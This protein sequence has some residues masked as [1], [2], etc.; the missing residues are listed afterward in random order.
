[1][2]NNDT[3]VAPDA[4][5][6]LVVEASSD[7][8][9][10][11]VGSLIVDLRTR[12]SVLAVGGGRVNFWLGR[13][14]HVRDPNDRRALDYVTGASMLVPMAVF[15]KI[16]FIDDSYFLYY[17]DA[18]F[19]FALRKHGYRLATAKK[20]FVFHDESSGVGRSSLKLCYY[21]NRSFVR[22][23]WRH[24]PVVTVS[25]LVGTSLRVL[26][27]V[28][29]GRFREAAV[30]ILA[31][32]DGWLERNRKSVSIEEGEVSTAMRWLT[33]GSGSRRARKADG[34]GIA[35][36]GGIGREP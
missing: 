31:V 21:M 26:K 8:N 20:S 23:T 11:A 2:L 4:L 9:I 13:A 27:R 36:D 7:P 1:L 5:E 12:D 18:D 35:D 24:S 28:V 16:G 22:F 29:A 34:Q 3:V 33:A 6:H 17:E 15:E 32:R 19:C 25:L 30:T 10:G 14:Q